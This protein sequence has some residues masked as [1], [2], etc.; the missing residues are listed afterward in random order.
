M[1]KIYFQPENF[2]TQNNLGGGGGI[3]EATA[4]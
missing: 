3:T 4:V 2:W 1:K